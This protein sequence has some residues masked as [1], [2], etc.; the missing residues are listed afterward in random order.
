MTVMDSSWSTISG[1]A[2]GFNYLF[3]DMRQ[4]SVSGLSETPNR[5][6]S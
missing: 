1:S 5:W 2:Y 3:Q 6:L 4:D